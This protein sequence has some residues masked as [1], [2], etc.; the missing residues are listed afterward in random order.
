MGCVPASEGEKMKKIKKKYFILSGVVLVI[1]IV[2]VLLINKKNGIRYKTAEVERGNISSYISAT[3]VVN[4]VTVVQ[5]GSQVS[6]IIQKIFVDYNSIVKKDQII[7]HIDPTF[8]KSQLNQV[9]ANLMKTK[10]SVNEAKRNLDRT[11]KLFKENLVAQS[12][13]DSAE[14]NY[15]TNLAMQKQASAAYESAKVNLENTTIRSPIDGIVIARNIDVGQTVAASFSAPTL[16]LIANDLS[17]MQVEANVDEA[18]IGKIKEGQKVTFTVDAYP[19]ETFQGRVIQI[20]LSP[21]TIQNVVTYNVIMR[22]DNP[23]LKLKPGMTA[24]VT[25]TVGEK[26]NILKVPNSALRFKPFGD[27]PSEGRRMDNTVWVNSSSKLQ[28]ES[29]KTGITDGVFTEIKEGTLKEGDEIVTGILKKGD[30]PSKSTSPFGIGARG[31]H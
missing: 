25:F 18:D 28:P 24:N 19:E 14:T 11:S 3:G 1:V 16:F 23:G 13:M 20:R 29:V 12:D 22:V 2:A 9:E 26:K 4:P 27:I 21:Q 17:K 8:F 15:E 6:G 7:T 30:E 10:V 31:R 5:V